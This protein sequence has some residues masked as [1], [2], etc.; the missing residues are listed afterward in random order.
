MAIARFITLSLLCASTLLGDVRSTTGQITMDV[1]NDGQ[2]EAVLSQ[3]GFNIGSA[4]T[5]QANLHVRGRAI[6]SEQLNL[7]GATGSANLNLSG[8]LGFSCLNTSV[9][10]N[11][12]DYS[13]V[14]A[15]T[16]SDNLILQLP[17]AQAV[18]GRQLNIKRTSTLNSLILS[19]GII[20]GASSYRI[21]AGNLSTIGLIAADNLWY[22]S[23][24]YQA[25][26]AVKQEKILQLD[27]EETSLGTVYDSSIYARTGTHK[28]MNSA[29]I[30]VNGNILQGIDLDG[31][32]SV[33]DSGDFIKVTTDDTS[34][35]LYD[36]QTFTLS[37]R[38]YPKTSTSTDH[39]TF[40]KRGGNE[41]LNYRFSMKNDGLVYLRVTFDGGV[42]IEQVTSINT[43][44]MN[45]WNH[46]VG[47][48][49][50]QTLKVFINGVL[51]NSKATGGRALV[52]GSNGLTIG[53]TTG[54]LQNFRGLMD[55]VR[56]Y[57]YALGD[58]DILK[59]Y[60][61]TFD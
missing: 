30:N 56:V 6:I 14:F 59:L 27:F 1:Q 17:P 35:S 16:S 25:E 9:S 53:G 54:G 22:V 55:D 52:T 42:D 13:Y 23:N 21:P 38:V 46:V 44:T 28:N 60:S 10:S 45:A 36:L 37:V 50:G 19:G 49:E 20:E 11:I 7:G 47:T 57:N 24:N 40:I 61:G 8:T 4:E 43:L 41:T 33:D 3:S 5:A 58:A 15:D 18:N 48:Y 26:H 51:D 2:S 39:L 32:P 29:N 34:D 12:A 31:D